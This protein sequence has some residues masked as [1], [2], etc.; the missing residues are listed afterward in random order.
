M[1]SPPG[2]SFPHSHFV[3]F[4]LVYHK[5]SSKKGG[6]RDRLRLLRGCSPQGISKGKPL[7]YA[8]ADFSRK[9]KVSASVGGMSPQKIRFAETYL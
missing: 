1:K 3:T 5:T 9:R 6:E 4:P 2:G 8:F 7:R